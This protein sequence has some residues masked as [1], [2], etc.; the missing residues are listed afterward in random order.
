MT[1]IPYDPINRIA[2]ALEK[3][4]NNTY[5]PQAESLQLQV[6][7][8]KVHTLAIKLYSYGIGLQ[9]ILNQDG[10]SLFNK[11]QA[12]R[13]LAGDMA[14]AAERFLPPDVGQSNHGKESEARQRQEVQ[15]SRQEDWQSSTGRM[16]RA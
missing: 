14:T 2:T 16:D 8:D 7:K 6:E 4:A 1:Q 15:G 10:M 11:A 9:T 12:L 3:I 13:K 5:P